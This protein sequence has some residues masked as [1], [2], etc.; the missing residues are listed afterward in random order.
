MDN[1]NETLR[2]K[3]HTLEQ[4]IEQLKEH[5][6]KYTAPSRSKTYYENHKT[7]VIQKVK[8]YKETTQ[9][10]YTPTSEQKKKWARTAYLKKKEKQDSAENI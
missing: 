5:L 9:Y 1:E 7:E 10:K 3:I 8:N 4:E 2:Q 6:K